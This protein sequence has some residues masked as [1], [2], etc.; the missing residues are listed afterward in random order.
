[1][2]R[3][4]SAGILALLPGAL[5]VYLAFNAGGYFPNT[6]GLVTI[7]LLLALAGWIGFAEEPFAGLGPW[8]ALATGALAAFTV[9]TLLSGAWSD[10]TARAL[11][12]FNRALL[13]LVALVLFGLVI[14]DRRQLQW[15][16][17]GLAAG[18][19][20]VCAIALTTR[21][22]PNVWPIE[23]N[24]ANERLSYP[25]TYWNALGLL[26]SV[27]VVFC[28]QM[29][30]RARGPALTRIMGAAA[31]PL[32]ATTVY[33]TFSRGAIA[34]GGI[35]IVAYLA[36]ARPRGTMSGL[37]AAVPPTV[38]AVVVAYNADLLATE[39]PTTQAAVSQGHRVAWVLA[40]CVAGAGVV[41]LLLLRL[42]SRLA[43]PRRLVS[44]RAALGAAGAMLAAA[45]AV[46]L[47]LGGPDWASRQYDR[48]T[49]D[50]P[51]SEG[52]PA[53][54]SDLRRR[55]TSVSSNGRLDYWGVSIDEF[56][57]SNL[58]GKGGGTFQLAWE[59]EREFP[60]TVVDAHG[61]YPET[62]GEL[63]G[64]G[65]ALLATALFAILVGLAMRVRREGRTL[66]AALLAAALVWA[67]AAAVDWHWE[68]P[69]V[70]LWLFAAGGAAIAARAE[71]PSRFAAPATPVRLALAIP[72]VLLA[73]LPYEVL[74]SQAWLDRANEAF[75]GGDCAAAS[76]DAR[77]SISALGARPEPYELLGYCAVRDGRPRQ[78]IDEMQEAV[79]RDPDNWSFHYGLALA[80]AAAGLDPRPEA[81]RA[82]QMNPLEPLA[83]LAVERFATDRPDLW[84]RRGAELARRFSS[85]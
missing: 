20:F 18:I 45:V 73:A 15:L 40:A 49:S 10:S 81:L 48:F 7:V 61:L 46:A 57:R 52:T 59:R 23:F 78:A 47:A 44:P 22:L 63:G 30:T 16:L 83:K 12:E 74:S 80:Q 37:M 29:A 77:S 13:Y 35:G 84:K 25:I 70:T 76:D 28:L 4:A 32:L 58:E 43:R 6:Q 69:V 66:Y 8:L 85:V 56:E 50:A 9:W 54:T 17:W 67:L 62:L 82:R 2:A 1:M 68:M 5:V 39:R 75:A 71:R 53:N 36:L 42:D 19:V 65:M 31:I 72:L 33:F 14:R 64:I 11:L 55:L 51:V 27:G 38:V 3:R 79:E 26:A 21:L 34:A 24:L 41:R 60:G